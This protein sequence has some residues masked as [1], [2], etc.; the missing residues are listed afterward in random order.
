MRRH[1]DIATSGRADLGQILARV[2]RARN[3]RVLLAEKIARHAVPPPLGIVGHG[4]AGKVRM[5]SPRRCATT[6]VKSTSATVIRRPL[7]GGET[8]RLE[9]VMRQ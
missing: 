2:T 7:F 4:N 5:V 8:L 3:E 9:T 1:S 6:T